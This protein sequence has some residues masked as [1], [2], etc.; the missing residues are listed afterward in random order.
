MNINKVIA[1]SLAIFLPSNSLSH[2]IVDAGSVKM[3]WHSDT[4]EKL[5]VNAE[6]TLSF[7]FEREGKKLDPKY[8]RCTLLLYKGKVSPRTRPQLLKSTISNGKLTTII[9]TI[10]QGKYTLVIDGKPKDI[11]DFAPF[12]YNISLQALEDVYNLP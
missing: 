4:N 12:R 6:S 7:A 9:T 2:Q 10:S 1:I 8:C 3:E 5:Q 11:K